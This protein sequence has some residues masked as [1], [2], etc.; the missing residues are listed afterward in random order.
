VFHRAVV[1]EEGDVLGD[2]LD[3]QDAA[4]F[5]VHLEGD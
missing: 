2:G 3:A 1:L 5:I 4:E